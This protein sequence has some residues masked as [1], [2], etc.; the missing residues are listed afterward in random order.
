M[1]H[2]SNSFLKGGLSALI[3]VTLFL[4]AMLGAGSLEPSAAPGPTM[5]T[6]DQI[7]P[8]WSQKISGAAR[9]ELV[10]DGEA[11]LD[12]ETGLVWEKSPSTS[13]FTWENAVNYCFLSSSL[14]GS[15]RGWHLPTIEQ[16]SSILDTLASGSLM[17]PTGHPF[18]NV[19][20]HNYWSATTK[21]GDP[22]Y[23]WIVAFILPG[24]VTYDFKTTNS[25]YVWCVR[26]GQSHNAY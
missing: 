25:N 20:E 13:T 9:F 15:R 2:R 16:L 1:R 6:L 14:G 26:G 3:A 5:K 7:P 24:S 10:L 18:L 21:A 8:T 17:L 22:T 19:Q 11:V 23:A 12:K 4:P